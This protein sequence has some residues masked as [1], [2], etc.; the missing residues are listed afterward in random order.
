VSI[1]VAGKSTKSKEKEKE[2]QIKKMKEKVEE[3][4]LIIASRNDAQDE[5]NKEVA[6]TTTLQFV[7]SKGHAPT[8]AF[9]DWVVPPPSHP[10]YEKYGFKPGQYRLYAPSG[11]GRKCLGL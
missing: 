5:G 11:R 10:L 6:T 4:A 7:W 1:G 9:T 8:G 2:R 3:S